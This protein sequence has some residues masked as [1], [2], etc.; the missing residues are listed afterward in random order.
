M[1]KLLFVPL[2]HDRSLIGRLLSLGF[3]LFRILLGLFAL[4]GISL[5]TLA[6]AFFWLLTPVLAFLTNGVLEWVFKSLLFSGVVLFVNHLVSHP[7]KKF[8]QIKVQGLSQPDFSQIWQC[9]LV[10]KADVEFT[11]LLKTEEVKSLLLYLEQ[12][13]ASFIQLRSVSEERELLSKVWEIGKKIGEPYLSAGYFFVASLALIP[14]INSQL[15]KFS[16]S[17]NDLLEV[18][19]FQ[20]RKRLTWRLFFPWDEEFRV[21]HLKGVNRGWIGA[22][23]PNLDAVSSDITRQAAKEF[24]PDFVGRASTLGE[25]IDIL[26]LQKGR[27]VVIV[28]EPGSGKSTLVSYL[29]KMIISGDAPEALATKRVVSLDLTKMLTGIKTQ[30]DLAEEIKNIFEEISYSGNIIVFID[31]IENLGLGEVGSQLNL[32]SLLLPYIESANIQ[33]IATADLAG[34]TRTLEK[35]AALA[36]L[37]TKVELLPATRVETLEILKDQAIDG[38][39]GQK[40]KTSM[41]AL[42]EIVLLTSQYIHDRVLPDAAIQIFEQTLGQA[43]DGWVKKSVVEEV[44]QQRVRVPVGEVETS[45]KKKLLN[46]EEVIHQELIDQNEAVAVV[47]STLRRAAVHLQDRS[48]PIGSFLFV[49]PTGV[50]KTELAKIIAE[51]YFKGQGL[52]AGRQGTFFRLDMS[53]YQNS[54]AVNRLIGSTQDEGQLTEAVR[55]NPY[56]LL[57]LDEFE[58]AD[59]KILTLFLQVLDDGRLTS[60]TGRTVD[61]TNTIIV[62]T[63]NAASLTVASALASGLSFEQT[64]KQVNAQLLQIFKP[65]LVNRFDEV[66]I[67]KPLSVADLEKVVLLKLR[68]LKDRLKDQ[69]YI[70]EFA[71]GL[72]K[73]L[74]EKG[75]DRV[76]GARPLR[77]LIQDTLEAKLSVLILEGRL[78]KGEK[79]IADEQLLV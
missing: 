55:N 18:L 16:L 48:K 79:F 72:I 5:I 35:N 17:L 41:L 22:P 66:V 15:F 64:K 78:P 26:S 68:D 38:E 47:A 34:Y 3:R 19:D 75:Y 23:T 8:W 73:K 25:V 42:R 57:L 56:T 7:H 31:E 67:F 59:P 71:Q 10:K 28:G 33:F 50:G 44:V 13:P 65:E 45:T 11:K 37:F 32:Y 9:S 20:K 70:L 14:N 2:F 58:K 6:V 54:E 76:L 63:S 77:R 40:I 30:G 4:T 1:W 49:G 29:A 51:E 61:F 69:G 12:T 36:R 74:A 21:R 46:L 53:E 27:N 39:R 62:A 60:A 43:K 52:P 24:L